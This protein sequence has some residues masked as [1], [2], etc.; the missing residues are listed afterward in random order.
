MRISESVYAQ[1]AQQ[2]YRD[3]GGEP[4]NGWRV[5]QTKSHHQ[6]HLTAYINEYTQEV[7]IAIPGT[8]ATKP[9]TLFNDLQIVLKDTPHFEKIVDEFSQEVE[10]NL[11]QRG[12]RH[13]NI[14]YTGHS[15]GGF[16]AQLAALK[17]KRQAVVFESP[18]VLDI[19][20]KYPRRYHTDNPQID[21]INTIPNPINCVTRHIVEPKYLKIDAAENLSVNIS[22]LSIY[23]ATL[24]LMAFGSDKLKEGWDKLSTGTKFSIKHTAVAVF[25]GLASW[26]YQG[27]IS[28]DNALST[29]VRWID[30][31][32]Q[33]QHY[34]KIS[35]IVAAYESHHGSPVYYEVDANDIAN[36]H[37]LMQKILA[38]SGQLDFNYQDVK[39]LSKLF[40]EYGENHTL[41]DS[42]LSEAT[43]PRMI[44][45][46]A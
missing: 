9:E 10:N 7:V 30:I 3:N 19:V 39:Q 6:Y 23:L 1:L 43:M 25:A 34:H 22:K 35:N 29:G 18:G 8:D 40:D 20:E 44:T 41:V 38:D 46:A 26:A 2:A 12:Q 15:L 13:Y 27:L 36:I 45:A 5:L 42:L 14:S 31:A 11:R 17:S 24:G 37:Q 21:I 16:L 33:L 32:N 4:P 28:S